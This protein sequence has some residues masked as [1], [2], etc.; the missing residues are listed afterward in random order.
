MFCA[1]FMVL[2]FKENAFVLRPT[3]T[4]FYKKMNTNVLR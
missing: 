2:L 3:C 1:V 4:N